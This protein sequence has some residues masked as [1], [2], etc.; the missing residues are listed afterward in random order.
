MVR[1]AQ[2]SGDAATSLWT[3][4]EVHRQQFGRIV[5]RGLST[6]GDQAER[7]IHEYLAAVSAGI[8]AAGAR[9]GARLSW[10]DFA[11]NPFPELFGGP[12][13]GVSVKVKDALF[14]RRFTDR[15]IAIA[16]EHLTSTDRNVMGGMLGL[17]TYGGRVNAVAPDRTASAQRSAIFDA[18]CT[19]GWIDP[20]ETEENL[21]WVRPSTGISLRTP[22]AYRSPARRTTGPSSTI[23]TP[24]SRI[25]PGTGQR[26][27][28]RR[29]TTRRTTRACS[30]SM[31]AGIRATCSGTRSRSA[32]EVSFPSPRGCE[33]NLH[34]QQARFL[35]VR[36][37]VRGDG[38]RQRAA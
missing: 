35:G 37:G 5:I 1:T 30:A 36:H 28:G 21:G 13:G 2:R 7:Q 24:T 4:L 6:A 9:E 32:P 16:H 14:K 18:A 23:P 15:Q 12:P 17:A 25:L 22:A 33:R 11:L 8:R 34:D 31:R 29:C 20:R 3:L 19:T 10:L 38:V 27:P 26:Y